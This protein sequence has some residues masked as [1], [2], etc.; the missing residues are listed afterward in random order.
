M[1]HDSDDVFEL[2]GPPA[3]T[4]PPEDVIRVLA[5]MVTPARLVRIEAAARGRTLSVIPV[6]DGLSDPHNASA[7]LRSAEAFGVQAVHLV[8]GPYGFRAA[9]SVEK[10]SSRWLDLHLH[11]DAASC[12][13]AVRAA[14]YS[15]FVAVMDGAETPE[16]LGERVA[17]GERI[18]V[19]MGN[20]REGVSE[21]MRTRAT[22]TYRVP[23]DGF[24]ESLNVSVA[25]ATTLYTV[26][27]RAQRTVDE[28]DVRALMARYL[29]HSVN[30]AEGVLDVHLGAH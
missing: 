24:V 27:R 4:R 19:V 14:G 13:D 17:R 20:E 11:V 3:L 18:A 28:A 5:P 15:L 25:A 16:A 7:I 29:M 9:R 6:L 1:R 8:P 2:A 26:T 21:A 10:G 23:M 12:A 22:G 30:D